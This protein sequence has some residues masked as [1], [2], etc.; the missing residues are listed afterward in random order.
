MRVHATPNPLIR[1]L[2]EA[3][4]G[5]QNLPN[6]TTPE[7]GLARLNKPEQIRTN[8]NAANPSDQIGDAPKIAP[9]S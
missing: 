4:K 6:R 8:P 2:T 1:G 5:F 7:H 9:N 3:D